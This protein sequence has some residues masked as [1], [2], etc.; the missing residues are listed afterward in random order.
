MKKNTP[1]ITVMPRGYVTIDNAK[2]LGIVINKKEDAY[3]RI[4]EEE[5][6][7]IWNMNHHQEMKKPIFGSYFD[8]L[9]DNLFTRNEARGIFMPV[10]RDEE[11]YAYIVGKK[12]DGLFND[13]IPLYKREGIET[14]ELARKMMKTMEIKTCKN[15]GDHYILKLESEHL[16]RRFFFHLKEREDKNGYLVDSLYDLYYQTSKMSLLLA[17]VTKLFTGKHRLKLLT[18]GYHQKN[19]YVPYREFHNP[20]EHWD[21]SDYILLEE[22][23][24]KLERTC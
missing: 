3:L 12:Q 9:R 4:S 22:Y 24:E 19:I 8:S 2:Q 7:P 21:E 13:Y 5:C 10:K 6:V 11:P 17:L 18:D 20:N 15:A 23:L 1:I 14:K 16:L